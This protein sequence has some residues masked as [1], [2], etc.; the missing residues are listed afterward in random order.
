MSREAIQVCAKT[1]ER[2][3]R[4]QATDPL[5]TVERAFHA[6]PARIQHVRVDHRRADIRV[7]EQFLH[8][9]DVLAGFQQMRREAVADVWQL[10]CFVALVKVLKEEGCNVLEKIDESEYGK[11]AWVIDPEGNKVELWQP[12]Q[13]Q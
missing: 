9:S 2:E 13:G 7:A 5:Q 4:F 6:Q 12:P 10:P 1:W 8:R 11:F 3:S